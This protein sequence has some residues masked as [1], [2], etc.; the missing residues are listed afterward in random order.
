MFAALHFKNA[1]TALLTASHS[2]ATGGN[3]SQRRRRRREAV[4]RRF[5]R[6]VRKL[7]LVKSIIDQLQPASVLTPYNQYELYS[8]GIYDLV[9]AGRIPTCI[10]DMFISDD[11]HEQMHNFDAMANAGERSPL[12]I[13]NFV[14]I[15]NLL[16]LLSSSQQ[17]QQQ[18]QQTFDHSTMTTSGTMIDMKSNEPIPNTTTNE[19]NPNNA[20]SLI[21]SITI[22]CPQHNQSSPYVMYNLPRTINSQPS[23]YLSAGSGSRSRRNSNVNQLKTPSV[24]SRQSTVC[25]IDLSLSLCIERE[26]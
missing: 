11:F 18:P 14:K 8:K 21:N 13:S 17:Q 2:A 5:R 23:Q 15:N 4:L 6:A 16:G 24:L 10:D 26:M 1:S 22:C 9:L 12:L 19:N 3:E 25:N 7:T 20:Q